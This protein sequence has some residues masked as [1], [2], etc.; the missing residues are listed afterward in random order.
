MSR[1][2]YLLVAV[3]VVLVAIGWLTLT[4][5]EPQSEQAATK[6]PTLTTEAVPDPP[7]TGG[8]PA[9]TTAAETV[10]ASEFLPAEVQ[11]P[12]RPPPPS[13]T[14]PVSPEHP[15]SHGE[16]PET[17]SPVAAKGIESDGASRSIVVDS[18][19]IEELTATPVAPGFGD[20]GSQIGPSAEP[21]KPRT[22]EPGPLDRLEGS[23]EPTHTWHD[24]DGT[25]GVWL[26]PELT[27]G[28]GGVIVP[29]ER[30]GDGGVK[31]AGGGDGDNLPVFRS[32]SGALMMLPGGVLLSLDP[33]WSQTR[34]DAFFSANGIA[35]HRVSERDWT[36][37]G[38]FIETDPGFPSLHLANHLAGQDG[39][40][41]SIPNWWTEITTR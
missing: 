21:G 20:A 17:A 34:I 38:F 8:S 40:E 13:T 4:R 28:V 1:G 32:S 37:N 9:E 39:V 18:D 23:G 12:D 7:T 27:V 16:A 14:H 11:S 36:P 30:E 3:A 33:E 35:S 41:F 2:Y 25:R 15:E 10:E 22:V 6:A 26:A 24:G 19:S 5:I 31:S 29:V